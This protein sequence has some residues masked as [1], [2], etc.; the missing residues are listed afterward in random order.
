MVSKRCLLTFTSMV[1]S[2]V[3]PETGSPLLLSAVSG[4]DD[5]VNVSCES[6]GWYPKPSLHWSNQEKVLT[7]KSVE[8]RNDSSGLLT[9]RSWLLVSSDSKVSCSVGLPGEKEKMASLCF[10]DPPQP[11][12]QSKDNYLHF[13]TGYFFIFTN[14]NTKCLLSRFCSPSSSWMGRLCWSAL[15]HVSSAWNAVLQKER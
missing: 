3:L 5:Q 2:F 14:K 6:A 13:L 9:V 1:S 11:D 7:P 12:K 10:N 4:E 15:S 8:Y